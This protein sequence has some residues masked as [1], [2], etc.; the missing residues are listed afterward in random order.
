M[1]LLECTAIMSDSYKDILYINPAVYA[2]A[3]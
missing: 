3:I 1:R 2:V